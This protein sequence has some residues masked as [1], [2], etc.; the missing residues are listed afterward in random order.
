LTFSNTSALAAYAAYETLL[1][2]TFFVT[3]TNSCNCK[4]L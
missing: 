3:T 4:L 1:F 2:I